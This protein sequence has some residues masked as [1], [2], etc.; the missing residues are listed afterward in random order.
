[1]S[2]RGHVSFNPNSMGTAL[3]LSPYYFSNHFSRCNHFITG[4]DL[5]DG[6]AFVLT[7]RYVCLVIAHNDDGIA[8]GADYGPSRNGAG[9]LQRSLGL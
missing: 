4:I 8:L 7:P 2:V 6:E 9:L 5:V 1:M 3:I